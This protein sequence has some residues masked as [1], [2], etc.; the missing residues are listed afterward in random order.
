M[1][2]SRHFPD[3]LFVLV[4]H[5]YYNNTIQLTGYNTEPLICTEN[6][7]DWKLVKNS[8]IRKVLVR[9]MARDQLLK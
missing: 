3:T 1:K 4:K 9:K 6:E 8:N 5:N 2:N 7:T